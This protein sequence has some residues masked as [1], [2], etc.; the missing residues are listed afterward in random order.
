MNKLMMEIPEHRFQHCV[1]HILEHEG[2]LSNHKRDPGGITQ[3]GISLR[4]LRAAG[5]DID[6]DGN[7]DADDIIALTR[8]GAIQIYRKYWWDKYKYIAFNEIEVVEKVFDMAVNMGGRAA[9]KQLQIAINR[10]QQ[11]PITVDGILGGQTFGAANSHNPKTLRQSLRDCAKHYY[12][13]IIANN[14]AMKVFED[15]W[16]RRAEW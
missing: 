2:G 14:P 15:G 3:W 6:G 11:K 8:P 4:F 12:R 13:Q 5:I 16:F 1:R 9:H 7:V 10:I